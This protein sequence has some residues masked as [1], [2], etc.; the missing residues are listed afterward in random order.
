MTE[1][2]NALQVMAMWL[3]AAELGGGVR[4][5]RERAAGT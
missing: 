2:R 5:A 4:L 1:L 3:S